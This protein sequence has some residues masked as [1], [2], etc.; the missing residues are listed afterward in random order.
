MSFMRW[1]HP[2]RSRYSYG[3]RGSALDVPAG[4][5][6]AYRTRAGG[7]VALLRVLKMYSPPHRASGLCNLAFYSL[8]RAIGHF[9]HFGARAWTAEG[10]LAL[11]QEVRRH[12]LMHEQRTAARG[13]CTRCGGPAA[14]RF[15]YQIMPF[16]SRIHP[17]LSGYV[18]GCHPP[19]PHTGTDFLHGCQAWAADGSHHLGRHLSQLASPR[20]AAPSL[21]AWWRRCGGKAPAQVLLLIDDIVR[22]FRPLVE[23]HGHHPPPARAQ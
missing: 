4:Q 13:T 16:L 7:Y 19:Y 10:A 14:L 11:Q 2:H 23:R 20:S 12:G 21:P 1:R 18:P 17:G 9:S 15:C 5:V 3:Q 8:F 22:H 6:L